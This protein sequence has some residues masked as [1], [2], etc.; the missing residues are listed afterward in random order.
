MSKFVITLVVFSLYSMSFAST[1][2]IRQ[3]L[4]NNWQFRQYHIGK[5]L[6]AEVSG[7]VHTDLINNGIIEDPF[8]RDNEKHIQWIDKADWETQTTRISGI[9]H[10]VRHHPERSAS[11]IYQQ[12]VQDLESRCLRPAFR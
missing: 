7:T 6:P 8:Y 3:E 4:G 12:Y 5:W 2:P 1:P 9:R 10:L 11:S